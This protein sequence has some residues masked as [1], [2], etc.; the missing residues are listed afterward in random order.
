MTLAHLAIVL[1]GWALQA[2][3]PGPA[4]LALSATAMGQG[5]RAA[6]TLALGICCGSGVWGLAA[7]LGLSTV[8]LAN[9]W[10]FEVLRYLGAGYLMFLAVKALRNAAHPRPASTAATEGH[11]LFLKGLALHLTNPKAIL[12]WG[13]IYLLALPAGAPMTQI[14]ALFACL[15]ATSA[16]IFVGYALMF[17]HPR[18]AQGYARTRRGFD[19]A[20]GVLFG[21]AGFGLLTARL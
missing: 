20:F 12:A 2:G 13:A 21:A 10:I 17:S 19:A 3:S 5:R 7:A 4:T 16:M 15:L 8:M 9:A 6:L 11:R 14:W 18:V 1:A